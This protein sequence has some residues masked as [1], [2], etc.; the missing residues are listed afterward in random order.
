[1]IRLVH[2]NAVS[3]TSIDATIAR[4]GALRVLMAAL[5]A[6]LRPAAP[7]PPP[8]AGVDGLTPHLRRDIGL[9]P[10]AAHARLEALPPLMPPV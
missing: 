6:L 10:E 1:M 2:T 7:H 4:H 9:P 8:E 5:G 3:E